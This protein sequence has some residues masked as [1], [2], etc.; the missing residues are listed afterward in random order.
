MKIHNYTKWLISVVAIVVIISSW[1]FAV[2]SL[3][4][5]SQWEDLTAEKWNELILEVNSNKNRLLNIEM[6]CNEWLHHEWGITCISNSKTCTTSWWESWIQAWTTTWWWICEKKFKNCSEILLAHSNSIDWE[7]VIDPFEDWVWFKAYCDMINWGWTRIFNTIAWT[8][9]TKNNITTCKDNWLFMSDDFKCINPDNFIDFRI[10]TT[11]DV[12]IVWLALTDIPWNTT[13][14]WWN[15]PIWSNNSY[16]FRGY[17]TCRKW[18]SQN[19]S[20]CYN[21]SLW[22]K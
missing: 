10:T 4:E 13:Y 17:W 11:N 1:T 19:L 18:T 15:Y 2:T 9:N 5:V 22:W 8:D 12:D 14:K 6:P 20:N 3:S 7:Y 16:T 21:M